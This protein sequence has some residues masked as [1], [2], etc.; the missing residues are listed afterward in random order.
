MAAI[1]S[2]FGTGGSS[3]T[4][5]GSS[6]PSLAVVLRDIAADLADLAGDAPVAALSAN[7]TAGALPA[8]TDPP[9]AGEMAALRTLVNEMRAVLVEIRALSV[10]ERAARA[11]VAGTTL[12]TTA[13]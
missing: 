2:N 12:R 9:T 5:A 6:Q 7:I 3:L 10:E 8:F 11:G 1:R 4:P 13:P